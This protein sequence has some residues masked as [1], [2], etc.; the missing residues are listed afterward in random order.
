MKQLSENEKLNWQQQI[1]ENPNF[2]ILPFIH[3]YVNTRG[4]INLCCAAEQIPEQWNYQNN[5]NLAKEW[6]G[7]LYQKMRQ[8]FIDG[9]RVPQCRRCWAADDLGGGSDRETHNKWF[10]ALPDFSLDIVNGNSYG[11]PSFLDLRPG[12]FCNLACRMCFVAVSSKLN[13]YHKSHPIL[14]EITNE[15]WIDTS[16]WIDDPEKFEAIKAWI[17]KTKTLKLAGG[18]PLFMPGVIRLLKWCVDSGN[19]HL[20]LDITTNGTRTKGKVLSYI[21][22]FSSVDIQLS[23]DGVGNTTEYIRQGS[24]WNDIDIAYTKYLEMD[25][26]TNLL[27]TAQIY[28]AFDLVNV[29]RYWKQKGA[30]NNFIFNFVDWPEELK[31]DLLPRDYRLQIADEIEK[32]FEGYPESSLSQ[33]RVIALCNRLRLD[34]IDRIDQLRQKWIK[35]TDIQDSVYKKDIHVLDPRLVELYNTWKK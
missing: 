8:A 34:D 14:S 16:D 4:D 11:Q 35:K 2:C 17:P 5:P 22:Q 23:L 32:E 31:I 33:F 6:S 19:T 30:N 18:E 21:E 13:D 27:V 24:N 9:E 29:V 1:K 10:W 12:N 28:N 7:E 25:V 20:H 15:E 3:G 26:R